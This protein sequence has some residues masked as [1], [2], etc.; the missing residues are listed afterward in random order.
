MEREH[1]TWVHLEQWSQE[2]ALLAFVTFRQQTPQGFDTFR[3][4][5]PFDADE[6]EGVVDFGVTGPGCE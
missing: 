3:S 5:F 6:V 4:F 2:M 1:L